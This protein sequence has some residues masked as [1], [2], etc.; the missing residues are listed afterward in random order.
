MRLVVDYCV[1][2]WNMVYT[3]HPGTQVK[4]MMLVGRGLGPVQTQ[5]SL[6]YK[7]NNLTKFN[8]VINYYT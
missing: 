5:R 4:G 3:A 6:Y 2:G 7:Q 1:P 8:H